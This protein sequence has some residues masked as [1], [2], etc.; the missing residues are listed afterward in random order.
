MMPCLHSPLKAPPQATSYKPCCTAA[1]MLVTTGMAPWTLPAVSI[2]EALQTRV[3]LQPAVSL[4]PA[5][6]VAAA[7]RRPLTCAC[8]A[9]MW[10]LTRVSIFMAAVALSLHALTT[11]T[12]DRGRRRRAEQELKFGD[13]LFGQ[14]PAGRG[15]PQER[16]AAGSK[17]PWEPPIVTQ[18]F[19]SSDGPPPVIDVTYQTSEEFHAE[20]QRQQQQGASAAAAAPAAAAPAAAEAQAA[21]GATAAP[22]SR[23]AQRG[24]ATGS[25]TRAATGPAVRLQQAAAPLQGG[26]RDPAEQDHALRAAA[27]AYEEAE[28]AGTDRVPLKR[29]RRAAEGVR[30]LRSGLHL[31][32]LRQ[33]Q[34]ALA[35]VGA[36]LAQT[37]QALEGVPAEELGPLV[38]FWMQWRSVVTVSTLAGERIGVGTFDVFGDKLVV[39]EVRGTV[40]ALPGCRTP[41]LRG[42]SAEEW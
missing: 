26:L 19:G 17:R 40:Q 16:P 8:R 22:A 37:A 4:L 1:I 14:Q 15:R 29:L 41:T 28:A 32:E 3:R 21:P 18:S 33:R 9:R 36:T 25:G 2:A 20:Q 10:G 11:W 27:Q 30:G 23:S 38:P 42:S 24:R 7:H 34:Q 12:G 6:L 35:A 5:A 13:P 39:W 31:L